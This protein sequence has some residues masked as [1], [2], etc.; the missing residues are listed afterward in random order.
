LGLG[1][2]AYK[3]R[4]NGLNIDFE[5]ERIVDEKGNQIQATSHEG[6]RPF[7][8][9]EQDKINR[10]GLCIGCHNSYDDPIWD[11]VIEI[12]GF[13]E[14]TEIHKEIMETALNSLVP[15]PEPELEPVIDTEPPDE[16]EGVILGFP[17]DA[18]V[19]GTSLGYVVLYSLRKRN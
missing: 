18:I 17:I 7:N 4:A 14:N 2:G 3:P 19:I 8:K 9:E 5:L 16:P 12:F 15:E 11:D 1:T 13:A 10:A 6:A